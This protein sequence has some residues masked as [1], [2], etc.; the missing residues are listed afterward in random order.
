MQLQRGYAETL[1]GNLRHDVHFT[2][3]HGIQHFLQRQQVVAHVREHV[4]GHRRRQLHVFAGIGRCVLA[5]TL[6]RRSGMLGVPLAAGDQ[7]RDGEQD[8][9]EHKSH[10]LTRSLLITAN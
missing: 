1:L 9:K 3:G 8:R 2:L 5:V 7:R 4:V 6:G 10:G